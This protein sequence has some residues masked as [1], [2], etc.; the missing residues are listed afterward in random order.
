[1]SNDP[2][3]SKDFA[4]RLDDL[5]HRLAALEQRRVADGPVAPEPDEQ[6]WA[7]KA[8][9]QQVDPPGAVLFTGTVTLTDGEQ[10]EWQEGRLV[11]QVLEQEWSDL[12]QSLNALAHPVRLALI[13]E[14]VRGHRTTSEL[15]EE[16]RFGTTGQLY[17]HLR[18][19]V[20]A[21]WLKQLGRGRYGVP[22]ERMV[23]LLA[24]VAG[25]DR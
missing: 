3:M 5:E 8:L 13:Q 15:A 19:L 2:G 1:M 25:A 17:H 16:E 6:F 22:V 24:I 23:P 14:V 4:R 12:A 20:S 11:E 9:K 7:L 21:G 18:Q 10:Y